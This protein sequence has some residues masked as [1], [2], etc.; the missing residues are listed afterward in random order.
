MTDREHALKV[1]GTL[2]AFYDKKLSDVQAKLYVELLQDIDADR[3][4]ATAKYHMAQS[5]WFPKVSELREGAAALTLG[6]IQP[7]IEA[8]GEVEQQMVRVG[9]VAKPEFSSVVTGIVVKSMGWK[10]LCMSENGMADRAH[11]LKAYEQVAQREQ[12][13]RVMLP[14]IRQLTKQLAAGND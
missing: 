11:F 14:E 2:E 9:H 1:I 12:S 10:N 4:E 7:A 6:A 8:W 3:L 5:P 13:E